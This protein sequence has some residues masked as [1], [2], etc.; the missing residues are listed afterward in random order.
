MTMSKRN[1]VL[2]G[3]DKEAQRELI[4][5][6]TQAYLDSGRTIEKVGTTLAV[7][8]HISNRDFGRREE[9]RYSRESFSK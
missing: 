2:C 9:D 6:D 7:I 3:N 4:A 5:Q 8:Y 1:A